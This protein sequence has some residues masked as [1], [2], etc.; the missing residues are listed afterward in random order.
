MFMSSY[1]IVSSFF[2][3]SFTACAFLF[4]KQ[5]QEDSREDKSTDTAQEEGILVSTQKLLI[6]MFLFFC[7][8]FE[9]LSSS[10]AERKL[11]KIV[12]SQS[13]K[14]GRIDLYNAVL[15]VWGCQIYT[16]KYH[17]FWV[18]EIYLN[19]IHYMFRKNLLTLA[20]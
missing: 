15:R 5:T 10:M 11:K 3:P 6:D 7:F 19:I 13:V 4:K 14:I 17:L 2:V 16:A 1:M 12:A 18:D 9:T 20:V 8:F